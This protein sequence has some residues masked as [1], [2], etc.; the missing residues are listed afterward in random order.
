MAEGMRSCTGYI[1][2]DQRVS[3][4][5]LRLEFKGGLVVGEGGEGPLGSGGAYGSEGG[6]GLAA[7]RS[8]RPIAKCLRV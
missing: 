1:P 6:P 3:G 4:W 7:P 5:D 8:P 2:K